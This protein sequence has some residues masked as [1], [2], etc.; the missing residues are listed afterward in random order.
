MERREKKRPKGVEVKLLP[1]LQ[2]LEKYFGENMHVGEQH[3]RLHSE[4]GIQP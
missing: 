2:Y 1:E 3:I 4:D